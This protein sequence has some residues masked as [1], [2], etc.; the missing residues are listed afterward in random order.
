MTKSIDIPRLRWLLLG[1]KTCAAIALLFAL[2]MPLTTCSV[3]GTLQ[4]HRVEFT[5]DDIGKILCFVWPIPLL[6]AQYVSGRVRRSYAIL[7]L[8]CFAAFIACI[9]LTLGVVVAA[10]ISLGGIHPADGYNLASSSLV[11]CFVLS[12]AQVTLTIFEHRAVM[13]ATSV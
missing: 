9:N 5:R 12:V 11:G 3:G 10:A 4:E 7:I 13:P 8:E 1:A 6:L 2:T